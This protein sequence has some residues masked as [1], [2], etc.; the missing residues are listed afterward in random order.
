MSSLSRSCLAVTLSIEIL[1]GRI[2]FIRDEKNLSLSFA[3][4]P[5]AYLSNRAET[6]DVTSDMEIQNSADWKLIKLIFAYKSIYRIGAE[7]LSYQIVFIERNIERKK[8]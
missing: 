7:D 6:S 1:S 2:S 4:N 8:F 5:F 3:V